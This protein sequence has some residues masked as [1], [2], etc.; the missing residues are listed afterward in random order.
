MRL[1]Q[2]LSAAGV[3]S[4]RRSEQ[5]ILDGRVTVN[6]QT[7]QL[8]TKVDP[9]HDEVR[10]DGRVLH[11]PLKRTY[12]MLNKPRGVV[13]T[14][15]D[16]KGRTNVAS[17]VKD[18]GVRLYPVGRL[19]MDSEGLLLLTDDGDTAYR[20]AHPSHGVKKTYKVWVSGDD[21]ESSAKL[22][23]T[24]LSDG[25]T[26]F[27]P[28][29]VSILSRDGERHAVLSVTIGEGKN[30]QVRRM[31]ALVGLQVKRLMRI[32]EGQ[33]RLGNLPVGHWRYLRT[34]EVEYLQSVGCSD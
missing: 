18:A 31:C 12:I 4:R 8:G 34:D 20:L 24:P 17:L 5:Y 32:S 21:P 25:T 26:G 14:L 28:A 29:E 15:S 23:C 27:R 16:E 33:L 6:G 3:C 2:F 13:T 10:F 19:D 7:V 1:Q 30:R 22:L 9:A 11:M